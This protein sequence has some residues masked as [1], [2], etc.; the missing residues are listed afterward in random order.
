MREVRRI[1]KRRL[2]LLLCTIT[3]LTLLALVPLAMSTR[4]LSI[5]RAEE[6]HRTKVTWG[7]PKPLR[8][9]YLEKYITPKTFKWM[10]YS[11]TI[12]GSVSNADQL[13][14]AL[15]WLPW[16]VKSMRILIHDD[17]D[18]IKMYHG[19]MHLDELEHLT[20]TGAEL[21]AKSMAELERLPRLK[22]LNIQ[23][24]PDDLRAFPKM[25]ALE[26]MFISMKTVRPE[27]LKKMYACPKLKHLQVLGTSMTLAELRAF[28]WRHPSLEYLALGNVQS[29]DAELRALLADI[30]KQAPTLR[31]LYMNNGPKKK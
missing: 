19:A 7:I 8:Q 5:L 17:A 23:W 30:R 24:A 25:P 4:A 20:F 13:A 11:V 26:H 22:T 31:V 27:S 6:G 29:T 16:T 21:D 12:D 9:Q 14:A 15:R 10:P 1:M 28:D 18:A 3:C 2:L